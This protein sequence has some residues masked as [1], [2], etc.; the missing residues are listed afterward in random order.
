ML[1]RASPIIIMALFA[2]VIVLQVAVLRGDL[3]E[4]MRDGARLFWGFNRNCN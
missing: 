3:G 2:G 4:G 1:K